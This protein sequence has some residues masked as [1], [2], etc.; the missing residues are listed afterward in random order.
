MENPLVSICC[1]SYNHERFIK[2]ALDGF[3]MQKTNFPFEIVISDDCSKDG[4]HDIIKEYVQKYP[5]II[6]DISPEH[7]LG[8][9]DNGIYVQERANGKYIAL[10]EGDDYWTDPYKLQKQFD[11]LDADET[12]MLCCT[13]C[14]VVSESKEL[15]QE[16]R[17]TVMNHDVEGRY[18]LRDFL[19]DNHQYPTLCVVYRNSH[20]DELYKKLRKTKN[21]CRGDW[22]LWVLL[23]SYGDAY[24]LNEITAAYRVNPLSVSHNMDRVKWAKSYRIICKG[25]ASVLPEQYAD[26]AKDLRD[27]RWTWLPLMFAYKHEKRYLPMIGCL[28]IVCLVCPKSLWNA[29]KSRNRKKA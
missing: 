23:L 26:I 13:D 15:I 7:N 24:Y 18:N 14:M 5:D 21:Y 3:L 8:A 28:I 1:I 9:F 12:L 27:T 10:C 17:A 11:I 20:K 2:D 22:P 6:R 29:W 16:K 25:V 19:K 4:T